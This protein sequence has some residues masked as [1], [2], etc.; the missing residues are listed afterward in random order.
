MRMLYY[1]SPDCG[2]ELA[3]NADQVVR[4]SKKSNGD[5][6]TLI[7]LNTGETLLSDDSIKTLGA[8]LEKL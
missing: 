6:L 1:S 8:R 2:F 7:H 3:V 4:L 5:D